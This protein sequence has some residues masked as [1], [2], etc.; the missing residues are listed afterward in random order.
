MEIKGTVTIS[1]KDFNELNKKVKDLERDNER[2]NNI[3]K[4]PE[5]S[6]A[7]HQLG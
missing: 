4:L 5:V 7:L 1:L 2:L 3:I 6:K